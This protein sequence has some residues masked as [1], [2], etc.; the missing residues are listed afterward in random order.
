MGVKAASE[1][2]VYD[3]TDAVALVTWYHSDTSATAPSA[4][5]TTDA[6]VTPTGWSK[7]E[8]SISSD[9]DL[10]KYVYSCLQTVWGDGT[11]DWGEVTLSSSFEAAK[12]AYNKALSESAA[13]SYQSAQPNL[14]PWFTTSVQA[15]SYW[16][17]PTTLRNIGTNLDDGWLH[18]ANCTTNLN[19]SPQWAVFKLKESTTYTVL[20]EIRNSTIGGTGTVTPRVYT[21]AN[22]PWAA[23]HYVTANGNGSYRV[24]AE[25]KADLSSGIGHVRTFITCSG[26][27]NFT[28]DIRIS[29]YEGDYRGPYKP[30]VDQKLRED[31]DAAGKTATD[32]I[33]NVDNDGIWVTPSDA[34]PVNGAAALPES[35]NP[36]S[37]WHIADAL[38]LWRQGVSMFKVWVESS[39]TKVRVGREVGKHLLMD[40]DGISLFNAS[41]LMAR[42]KTVTNMT[43][44]TGRMT[45][46]D[47]DRAYIHGGYSSTVREASVEIIA[48]H[49]ES[50]DTS[51]YGH[52]AMVSLESEY[53]RISGEYRSGVY[54]HGDRL[55]LSDADHGQRFAD[56]QRV[57]SIVQGGI[58][59][60]EGAY[61]DTYNTYVTLSETASNFSRL[62]VE[63][64]DDTGR[65]GSVWVDS[66]NGSTFSMQTIGGN[67]S[68]GMVTRFKSASV[69]GTTIDTQ[70]D[71]YNRYTYGKVTISTSN[72][73]TWSS[74]QEIG[75]TKVVGFY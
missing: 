28:G 62:L 8:P 16:N 46:D 37:G 57:R 1:V 59:L 60:F 54:L 32:Y 34:K 58:V 29:I 9:G 26:T 68:A 10:T 20:F 19:V 30:Y 38:E 3:Q 47:D 25:T 75:I 2:T 74:S 50:D 49:G 39:V 66:P 64:E 36:T 53:D 55:Y 63:Y 7:A 45:F 23:N 6:S 69:S 21:Q 18:L 27:N 48:K 61:A 4:P 5:T 43:A 72:G 12:R 33:T 44:I 65:K 42:I 73:V 67:S 14:F 15:V 71:S 41:A 52:T 56:M 13:A 35:A 17:S 11:C 24:V 22:S 40:D 31:V 70:K 51:D